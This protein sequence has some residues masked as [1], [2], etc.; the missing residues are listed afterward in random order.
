MIGHILGY[1]AAFAAVAVLASP[2]EAS[3]PRGELRVDLANLRNGKGLVLLCLSASAGHFPNC[4]ADP[5]A[6]MLRVPADSARELVFADVPPGDYAL[7]V[8]HDE[9]KNGRLDTTLAIPREG[10]GFSRNPVVRFGPPAFR[11]V[12]FALRAGSTRL[13]VRMKYFL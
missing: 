11:D 10:F 8:M 7:S 2:V 12:R 6:R 9:N 1:G 5:A 13:P 3:A 4:S